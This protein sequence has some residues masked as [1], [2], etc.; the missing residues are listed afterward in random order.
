MKA[1]TTLLAVI[2]IALF[3]AAWQQGWPQL[4][5]EG[6][7]TK[8][9]A[10]IGVV[11]TVGYILAFLEKWDAV[12]FISVQI[13]KLGLIGTLIGISIAVQSLVVEETMNHENIKEMMIL[14]AGG[15]KT[16]LYTTIVGAFGN[17]WLS[18]TSYGR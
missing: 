15:L 3:G 5:W 11:F 10:L 4:I 7:L 17:I 13:L 2:A 1:R 9:S 8:I 18:M 12:K 16:A 6:D 14:M